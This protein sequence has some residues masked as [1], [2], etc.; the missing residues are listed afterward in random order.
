MN[1]FLERLIVRVLTFIAII[2]GLL[3]SCLIALPLLILKYGVLAL[4]LYIVYR[5]GVYLLSG[6]TL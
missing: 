6:V 5:I 1:K 4:A 2:I 3:G